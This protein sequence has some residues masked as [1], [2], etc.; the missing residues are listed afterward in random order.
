MDGL[1]GQYVVMLPHKNAVITYISNKPQNM[2]GVL[3]L[4]WE[5]LID[6][7]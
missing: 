1:Y 2:T 4:T 5:T 3:E 6:K 7:L